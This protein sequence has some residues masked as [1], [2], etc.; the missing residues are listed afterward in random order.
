MAEAK[1]PSSIQLM[2]DWR[3][4]SDVEHTRKAI[5]HRARSLA[6]RLNRMADGLE[7][8]VNFGINTVGELQGNGVELD[9]WCAKLGYQRDMLKDFEQ[10]LAHD[11]KHDAQQ[12]PPAA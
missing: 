11:A 8:D 10:A 6:E 2:V 1:R 4:R 5:I 12:G 7:A 9:T 3:L